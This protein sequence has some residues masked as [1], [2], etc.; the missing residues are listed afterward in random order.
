VP[1]LNVCAVNLER[2]RDAMSVDRASLMAANLRV[3]QSWGLVIQEHPAAFQAIKYS[4]RFLDQSCLAL[5][6]RDGLAAKL[7]VVELGS[8]NEV[9]AATEW[10]EE[11]KAALV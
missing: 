10:L 2:T 7:R 8:L 4:S 11:R 6:D 5:F 3:P 9:G 1:E